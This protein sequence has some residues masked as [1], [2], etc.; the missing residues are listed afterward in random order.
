[1]FELDPGQWIN[2][3]YVVA[4][5]INRGIITLVADT[6]T[7]VRPEQAMALLDFMKKSKSS[8]SVA[9]QAIEQSEK[10]MNYQA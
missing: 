9:G 10:K 4:I 8:L 2:V 6:Y 5:D 3:D 7:D 1:M